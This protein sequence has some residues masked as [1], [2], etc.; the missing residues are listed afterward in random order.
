MTHTHTHTHTR[1]HARTHALWRFRGG[2]V[3][4]GFLRNT[5]M[6]HPREAFG[7]P[8]VSQGRSVRPSVKY[9][10]Q[11]TPTPDGIYWGYTH[12]LTHREN[13]IG[14][15]N[16][17]RCLGSAICTQSRCAFVCACECVC[18]CVVVSV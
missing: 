6:D 9:F 5:S 1:T 15:I 16:K 10:D 8:I 17:R 3:A 2:Q 14:A 4:I 13:P 18:M 11:D 12:T 7:G